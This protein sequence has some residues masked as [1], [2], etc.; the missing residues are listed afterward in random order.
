MADPKVNLYR[1][2]ATVYHYDVFDDIKNKPFIKDIYYQE[3]YPMTVVIDFDYNKKNRSLIDQ[4]Y[5]N[6][7]RSKRFRDTDNEFQ[8]RPR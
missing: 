5:N 3:T 8:S 4:A 7:V 6:Y 1:F 2:R